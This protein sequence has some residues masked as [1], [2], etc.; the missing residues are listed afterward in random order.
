M[1]ASAS[2]AARPLTAHWGDGVH[3]SLEG[4][5]AAGGY[6]Q[7]H[8]ALRMDPEE[9]VALVERE[10]LV[11][12]TGSSRVATRWREAR[13]ADGGPPVLVAT[14]HEAEPG[15]FQQRLLIERSPHAVLEGLL[16]AARATGARSSVVVVR[17]EYD[18]GAIALERAVAEAR[19]GGQLGRSC[20]RSRVPHDVRIVR[21]AGSPLGGEPSAVLESLEGRRAMPRASGD[22][23]LFGHPAVVHD[24]ETL[25]QLAPLLAREAVASPDT[26]RS[27]PGPRTALFAVSGHV[28]RPGVYELPIATSLD[29][30]VFEHAGG[31]AEGRRLKGVLPGGISSPVLPAG[32]LDV[33]L[34]DCER[35]TLG[36]RLATRAVIVLDE[37]TCM[38]RVACAISDFHRH[39]SCGRCTPCREGTAWMHRIV[40]RIEQ[41]EATH[42]ELDRVERLSRQLEGQGLCAISDRAAWPIAGLLRHFGDEF[43]AHVAEHRCPFPGSFEA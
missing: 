17:P 23:G 13:E 19:D 40:R 2:T 39:E 26:E 10:A 30:I 4:F 35:G 21:G 27:D 34:G 1:T 42:E 29:R 9:L 18:R 20:L 15:A 28:E 8:R 36:S 5:T 22:L 41:G 12:P 43:R 7:A 24:V 3:A 37:T 38:V 14:A 6:V 32:Q 31:V 33:S 25:C 11:A 16:I